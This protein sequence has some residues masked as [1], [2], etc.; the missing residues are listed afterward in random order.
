MKKLTP[1]DLDLRQLQALDAIVESGTFGRAAQ[2]L[3]Y[4]QSAVS[5]QIAGLEKAVGQPLFDRT[6]GSRR[7]VLTPL[8]EVVAEQARAVLRRVSDAVSV[9]ERFQAGEGGRVDIGTFQ[10]VSTAVLPGV[11]TRL[12][13]AIPG[14]GI[15]LVEEDHTRVLAESLAAGGLD[16]AFLVGPVP[17]G[18]DGVELFDDPFCV[19]ALPQDVGPGPVTAA[20]LRERPLIA[21]QD[22]AC[23]RLLDANLIRIGVPAE[24]IFRASDNAAVLAMVAAGMGMT[25]RPLLAVDVDDPRLAIRDVDP[26]LP[27]RSVVLA[28]RRGRTLSPTAEKVIELAIEL[29]AS[30]R[31]HAA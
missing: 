17:P 11:L 12:Q 22:N 28:W 16:V 5:Q 8:G 18:L 4:T 29:T 2:R 3:G 13:A 7:P 1:R 9:I 31:A 30:R 24:Y 21:E 20:V 25:L 10:S 6:G 19:V 15:G 14:V 23:Q 26:P 27:P